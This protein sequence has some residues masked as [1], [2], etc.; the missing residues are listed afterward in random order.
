MQVSF[1]ME[2]FREE[3]EGQEMSFWSEEALRKGF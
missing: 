2:L 1:E 3:M